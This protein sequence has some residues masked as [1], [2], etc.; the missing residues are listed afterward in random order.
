MG[1]REYKK[2]M[3]VYF[4]HTNG[5]RDLLFTTSHWLLVLFCR[6][7]YKQEPGEEEGRLKT[8][9][10]PLRNSENLNKEI[11]AKEKIKK[12][13]RDDYHFKQNRFNQIPGKDTKSN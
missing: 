11:T 4:I 12:L 9:D 8:S 10:F 1:Q 7:R 13:L 6:I 5:K 2:S 3:E